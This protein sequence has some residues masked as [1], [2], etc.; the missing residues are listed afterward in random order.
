MGYKALSLIIGLEERRESGTKFWGWSAFFRKMITSGVL[1]IG[2]SC[3]GRLILDNG[4]RTASI[5][6]GGPV[7]FGKF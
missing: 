4:G 7:E 2:S 5:G 3:E 1:I 6:K